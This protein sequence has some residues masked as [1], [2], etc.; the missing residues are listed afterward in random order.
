MF[1]WLRKAQ[2]VSLDQLGE[3]IQWI[4]YRT[5]SGGP[6]T[7]QSAV[8]TPAVFCAARIIAEGIAQ[9]PGRIV[10]EKFQ[11]GSVT[12]TVFVERDH[13]A[14][15]LL[16]VPASV[17]FL[18][19]EPMLGPIRGGLDL[20]G[21]DW[22]IVGGESGAKARPIQREWIDSLR[23]ECEAARVAFFF[24]QWGGPSATAGGCALDGAEVKEWPCA[25]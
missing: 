11:P 13:W 2:V 8:D 6:V 20:H 25:A 9:M 10:R 22:V 15:K 1:G 3:L 24:K 21:L 23:R 16:A 5:T 12:G 14:H 18:S 4:G 19:V 7:V 17:R